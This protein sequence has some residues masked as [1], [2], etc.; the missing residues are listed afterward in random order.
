MRRC[1]VDASF[2]GAWILPDEA[3]EEASEF[4]QHVLE[5]KVEILAPTLWVY[6]IHNLL[7][8]AHK[9][10]R[11]RDTQLRRAMESLHRVPITLVEPSNFDARSRM[12]DY[13]L[14][15]GLSVYDASYLEL[16]LR[17]GVPLKTQD[18]KLAAAHARET[19][20]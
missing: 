2:C 5:A 8:S 20:A 18:R 7:L 16:A 15:H 9:R 19:S 6:E 11:I 17:M 10:S 14:R 12:I 4:L 3:S 1:V 13:S